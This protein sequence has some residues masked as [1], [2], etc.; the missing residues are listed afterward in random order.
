MDLAFTPEE[1]AFRD[2][3]RAWIDAHLDP[4]LAA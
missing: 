1:R 2:H 3:V 4:A